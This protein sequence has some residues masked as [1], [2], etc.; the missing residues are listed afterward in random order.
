M[1]GSGLTPDKSKQTVLC[2]VPDLGVQD[3]WLYSNHSSTRMGDLVVL[4]RVLIIAKHI[5]Y[6]A[7]RA[8][9]ISFRFGGGEGGLTAMLNETTALKDLRVC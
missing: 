8:V 7:F 9:T 5:Y 3:P 6:G 4:E 1:C 2:K